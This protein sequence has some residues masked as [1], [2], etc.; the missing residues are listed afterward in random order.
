MT[1]NTWINAKLK[2][3]S[4]QSDTSWVNSQN[5]IQNEHTDRSWAKGVKPASDY[6][7]LCL[8]DNDDGEE[9]Q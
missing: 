8:M 3:S 4:D 9:M 5:K 6:D 1:D 7:K 2:L